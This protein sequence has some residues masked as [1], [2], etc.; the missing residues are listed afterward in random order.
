M[1]LVTLLGSESLANKAAEGTAL[2]VMFR[3]VGD[4]RIAVGRIA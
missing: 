3:D 1:E 2:K 4:C